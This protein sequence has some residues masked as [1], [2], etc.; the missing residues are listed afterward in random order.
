MSQAIA[1]LSPA[2]AATPD[3]LGEAEA[4]AW[5]E[6]GPL[7]PLIEEWIVWNNSPLRHVPLV[8]L[9]QFFPEKIYRSFLED[10]RVRVAVDRALRTKLSWNEPVSWAPNDSLWKIAMLS[11]ERFQR[12]ALLGVA[13]TLHQEITQIIDGSIIRLLR[14]EIGEDLIQFVLFSSMPSKYFLEPLKQELGAFENH[15]E[16]LQRGAIILM[17]HAFSSKEHGVQK[18][19]ATKLPGCFAQGCSKE[20]LPWASEAEKILS[21]LWKETSSWI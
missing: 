8:T 14:K 7:A 3:K 20:A 9:Q 16:V 13:F 6:K 15:I 17:E 19:I 10:V 21:T 12:L 2:V 18:R 1:V 11:P 5:L 4:R